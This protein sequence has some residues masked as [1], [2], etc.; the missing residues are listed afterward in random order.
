MTTTVFERL[1]CALY[2]LASR[3]HLI[4]GAAALSLV[5]VT[6]IQATQLEVPACSPEGEVCTHL[7]GCC[8][9]L[10]CATSAINPN[11]GVCIP[12]EGG[13]RAVTTQIV[14]PFSDDILPQ[15]AAEL[16]EADA[17]AAEAATLLEQRA[18]AKDTRRAARRTRKDAQRVRR[19]ARVEEK[20]AKKRGDTDETDETETAAT[21]TG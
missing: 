13:H 19:Q 11:Y 15:M 12:G 14:T 1:V 6:P 16:V 3:R 17:A 10:V 2:R 8:D 18:T 4:G 9:G 5:R 21:G 20:R 7:M